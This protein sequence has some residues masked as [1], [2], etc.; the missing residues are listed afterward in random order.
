MIYGL[1]VLGI[2][3]MLVYD[4]FHP[5]PVNVE[6]IQEPRERQ[7]TAGLIYRTKA[8]RKGALTGTLQAT[9]VQ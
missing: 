2:G 3:G 9:R 6:Q 8:T 4:F 1:I 5:Q 7:H